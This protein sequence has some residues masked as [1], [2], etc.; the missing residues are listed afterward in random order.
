MYSALLIVLYSF[1]LCFSCYGQRSLLRPPAL[2]QPT[3]STSW[4]DETQE[5]HLKSDFLEA[6][7]LF[8]KFDKK[9]FMARVLPQE[10]IT[11][12][13]S[14]KAVLGSD[15]N[16]LIEELLQEIYEHKKKFKNFTILKSRDFNYRTTSGLLILKFNDHPFVIKLFMETPESFVKPFSKGWQPGC[17]FVM[18]GGINR[19][20]SGFTRIKNLEEIKKHIA[21]DSYWSKKLDTP[22]KWFWIPEKCR[23]FN[24]RS[25]YIGTQDYHAI[26]PSVYAIIADEIKTD[27]KFNIFNREHRKFALG[28]CHFLGNRIDPHIDN[29]MKEEGT[30][31]T[32]LADTEHFPT[33][34]GLRKELHFSSYGSWYA[35]LTAKCVTDCF[36]RDKSVRKNL[37][38]N[39]E[40]ILPC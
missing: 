12:R 8:N 38:I 9:Y 30:G 22:R 1:S 17:F 2:T 5:H 29:F 6:Q 16:I 15:L 3:I 4:V 31:I 18:G 14:E 13:N 19:Y 10:S 23:W 35:Q 24:L 39:P 7:A 26:L 32:L 33:M 11:Y 25:K 28:L 27:K 40:K 20:L 37:Q 34:I 36:F 21:R